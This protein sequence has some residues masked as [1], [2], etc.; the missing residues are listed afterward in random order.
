[1]D[2]G[3]YFYGYENGSGFGLYVEVKFVGLFLNGNGV[4]VFFVDLISFFFRFVFFVDFSM[5]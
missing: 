3:N 1:M 2:F 4:Y 5:F